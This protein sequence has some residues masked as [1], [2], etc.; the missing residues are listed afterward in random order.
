MRRAARRT[1]PGRGAL[2]ATRHRR[3][4]YQ[5]VAKQGWEARLRLRHFIRH[6][7][8][9]KSTLRW[10]RGL[11]WRMWRRIGRAI[12]HESR[13]IGLGRAGEDRRGQVGG[14]SWL[15]GPALHLIGHKLGGHRLQHAGLAR[16]R[17]QSHL[18]QRRQRQAHPRVAGRDQRRQP[19]LGQ[20]RRLAHGRNVV[21][22]QR[23]RRAIAHRGDGAHQR[24]HAMRRLSQVGK[25]IGHQLAIPR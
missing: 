23:C 22:S 12:V 25:Q 5:P 14:G 8:Q 18:A 13:E 24:P 20:A 11:R 16:R 9:S 17:G 3:W 10:R 2:L 21:A 7:W 4:T 6:R 1:G 19:Q 15:F